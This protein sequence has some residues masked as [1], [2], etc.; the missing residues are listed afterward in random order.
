[1][2]LGAPGAATVALEGRIGAD[3]VDRSP[4]D[5]ALTTDARRIAAGNW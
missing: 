5:G 1:M 2:V 4:S 3:A